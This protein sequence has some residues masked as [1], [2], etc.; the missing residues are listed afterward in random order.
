MKPI[1][2]HWL[3]AVACVIAVCSALNPALFFVV[4]VFALP[5]SLLS[6]SGLSSSMIM[7]AMCVLFLL[8]SATLL[9]WGFRVWNRVPSSGWAS[10]VGFALFGAMVVASKYFRMTLIP[11]LVAQIVGVAGV[12]G[13]FAR[14]RMK[15]PEA[16]TGSG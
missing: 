9:R 10:V 7:I 3:G 4:M 15:E 6:P 13:V 8:W 14:S 16:G 5:L 12:L 2:M 11:P 1:G